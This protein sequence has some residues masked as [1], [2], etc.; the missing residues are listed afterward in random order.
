M[1]ANYPTRAQCPYE[2]YEP[3]DAKAYQTITYPFKSGGRSFGIQGTGATLTFRFEY[4]STEAEAAIL[5]AH[6][7]ECFDDYL[8]FNFVDPRTGATY[9]NC[10]YT[11]F[12][13]SGT[14]RRTIKRISVEFV[15]YP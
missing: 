10:H 15:K 12:K 8:G 6:H 4:A 14:R 11:V 3:P 13:V 1:P 2:K 7:D 9:T 5:V